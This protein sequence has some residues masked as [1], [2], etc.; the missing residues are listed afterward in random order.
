[1]A[2]L[3][4]DGSRTGRGPVTD[5]AGREGEVCILSPAP[6]A[7][8]VGEPR[9]AEDADGVSREEGGRDE[10]ALHRRERP[11]Q[12]RREEDGLQHVHGARGGRRAEGEHERALVGAP[13]A[14]P[15]EALVDRERL[16][17]RLSG[18]AEQPLLRP[19]VIGIATPASLTHRLAP[20]R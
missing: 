16:L 15:L 13:A 18:G 12:Q 2:G 20:R 6:P 5:V 11:V 9:P 7:S 8:P 19:G 4:A 17:E 10:P 14:R 1:M 3:A